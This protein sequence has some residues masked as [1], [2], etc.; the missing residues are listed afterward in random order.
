MS[1]LKTTENYK[2]VEDL[3]RAIELCSRIR[4]VRVCYQRLS[5]QNTPKELLDL[6][7]RTRIRL[8]SMNNWR[9]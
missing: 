7:I 2:T 4:K 6:F 9:S 3:N 5:T 1:K 8:E